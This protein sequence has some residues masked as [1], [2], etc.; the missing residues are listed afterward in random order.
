MNHVS[1]LEWLTSL[2]LKT[3][4]YFLKCFYL[5]VYSFNVPPVEVYGLGLW[6]HFHVCWMQEVTSPR[7]PHDGW[8]LCLPWRGLLLSL[9]TKTKSQ[10]TS[11]PVALCSKNGWE[12]FMNEAVK[13]I[14]LLVL[15]ICSPWK[16]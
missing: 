3:T 5:I 10:R 16:L 4:H 12:I 14:K 13:F 2:L 8:C 6:V 15:G 7:L 11:K 1:F 9:F